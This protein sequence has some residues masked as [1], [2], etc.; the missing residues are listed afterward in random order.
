MSP[1]DSTTVVDEFFSQ[2]SLIENARI[3][4]LIDANRAWILDLEVGESE[5]IKRFKSTAD[6]NRFVFIDPTN[7][8]KEFVFSTGMNLEIGPYDHHWNRNAVDI[9]AQLIARQMQY[10]PL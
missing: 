7:K 3:Y 6:N 5:D 1:H 10:S 2:L 9:V 4:L 8:F